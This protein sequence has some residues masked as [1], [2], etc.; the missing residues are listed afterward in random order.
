MPFLEGYDTLRDFTFSLDYVVSV[1]L[2]QLRYVVV[3]EV[4]HPRIY[5]ASGSLKDLASLLIVA[6][7]FLTRSQ[8]VRAEVER[9]L[10]IQ[11][12][13]SDYFVKV[14]AAE[15]NYLASS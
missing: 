9:T 7:S 5:L 1:L 11:F 2:E 14:G 8:N 3:D 13:L 6:N 10:L 4:D 12:E 15:A